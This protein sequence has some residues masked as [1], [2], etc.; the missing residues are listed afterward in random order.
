VL[1][2]QENVGKALGMGLI[3]IIAVVMVIYALVQRRAS[4]WLR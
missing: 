4:K 1:A 3:I 2:G